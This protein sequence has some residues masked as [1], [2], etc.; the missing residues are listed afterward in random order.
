MNNSPKITVIVAVFNGADTIERCINSVFLQKYTNKELIIIDGLSTDGT[1]EIIK[2]NQYKINYWIS[3]KDN[4]ITNAWNKGLK[5]ATGD[6]IIFLG[7][8]DLFYNENVLSKIERDLV[9][10]KNNDVV[11]G[12]VMLITKDMLEKGVIGSAFN[13]NKFK[14]QMSLPHQGV[15]HSKRLFKEE[16]NFDE[17][18][19]LTADYDLLL[20]KKKNIEIA[21]ID[22]I[23]SKMQIGG[24][25]QTNVNLVY[26]EW[27]FSQLK[28]SV[29][30]KYFLLL[31]YYFKN[32]KFFIKKCIEKCLRNEK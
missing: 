1:Q 29:S 2:N 3:E 21:F 5:V 11:Y 31:H 32:V 18:L 14:T 30:N 28:Y 9:K 20:R 4:G 10:N 16:G 22:L 15:F 25:S 12:K 26:K 6:W 24:L 7:A 23:I 19:K 17:L 27:L 8:D 13:W